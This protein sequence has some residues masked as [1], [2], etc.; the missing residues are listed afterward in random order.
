MFLAATI[1]TN[2]VERGYMYMYQALGVEFC[3]DEPYYHAIHK[4]IA[5]DL[6]T[7]SQ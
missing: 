2:S 6:A 7:S 3:L 5:L 1:F 4:Y